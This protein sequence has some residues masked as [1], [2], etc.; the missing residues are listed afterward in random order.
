[1]YLS[2]LSLANFRNLLHLE[3]E[4]PPGVVVFWGDNAQG[5]TTLLEAVYLLAIARSFRAENEREVVNFQA[6]AQ[7]GQA[8][9]GGTI[10][11]QG[12]RLL[13]YV[14]YQCL[15]ASDSSQEGNHGQGYSVR[16]QIRVSRVRRTAAE[17]VGMVNAV[18]FSAGDLELIQGPPSGRRRYLD[19]LISQVDRLYLRALQRYHRVVQQRN[20]LLRM[21]RDGRAG[22]EELTFWNDELARE[23][24]A[25]TWRRLEAMDTLALLGAQ[26]HEE[27]TGGE[28]HL[29]LEYHPNVVPG[30]SLPDTESRLREALVACHR[31]ELAA[32]ATMVG[33]HRDNF[34]LLVEGV[35]MGTFASR[36]QARTLALTLR[37]AEAAYLASARGEG[38]IILLDDVLS[39]T[40]ARRRSRVLDKATQYQQVLITTTDVEP[41]RLFFGA[42]ATYFRVESGGVSPV[43]DGCEDSGREPGSL[44]E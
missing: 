31:R 10:E 35:D 8:W 25:I 22:A 18:L 21:V 16:K 44:A 28:E 2:R 27:L 17:L 29:C 6:A 23:G 37:L 39:E 4:L 11:K 30:D 1:V 42:A 13:V 41:I 40:D 9:V 38:P 5:K 34:E 33:P 15:P 24:A 14:G 19:I 43:A 26:Q 32:S 7:L 12:E 20:Q 3:L 36:G